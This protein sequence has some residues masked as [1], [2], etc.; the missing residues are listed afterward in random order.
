MQLLLVLKARLSSDQDMQYAGN[1][2]L[3]GTNVMWTFRT[4]LNSVGTP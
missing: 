3:E 1:A 4:F 2:T